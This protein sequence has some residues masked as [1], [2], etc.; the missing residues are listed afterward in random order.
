MLYALIYL[1]ESSFI[2]LHLLSYISFRASVNSHRG[3]FY[4]NP[5]V[6]LLSNSE[7]NGVE[8]KKKQNSESLLETMSKR[9]KK[10]DFVGP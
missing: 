10:K 5:S 6:R 2:F 4:L 1:R 9:K 3:L 8:K 7:R